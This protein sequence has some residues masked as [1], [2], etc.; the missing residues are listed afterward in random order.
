M[1]FDTGKTSQEPILFGKSNK[2]IIFHWIKTTKTRSKTKG[3]MLLILIIFSFIKS[4]KSMINPLWRRRV[5]WFQI[6][7]SFCFTIFF[8]YYPI[9]YQAVFRAWA[10]TVVTWHPFW[11]LY[12]LSLSSQIRN[13]LNLGECGIRYWDGV[14]IKSTWNLGERLWSR[15]PRLEIDAAEFTF[16]S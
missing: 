1:L 15:R 7:V 8:S 10:E 3:K 6:V 9:Y 5:Y 4:K 16:I 11:M 2:Y 13:W 12:W 14:I